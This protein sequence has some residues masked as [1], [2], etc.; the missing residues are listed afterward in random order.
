MISG[1]VDSSTW[2]MPTKLKLGYNKIIFIMWFFNLIQNAAFSVWA[3]FLP[4][5][6]ARK[7]IEQHLVGIMFC[8]Y[9]FSFA[10]VSPI[11]GLKMQRIGRRNI[12]VI[13]SVWSTLATIGFASLY[14]IHDRTAF[15]CWF[16]LFKMIL[17]IGSG[18]IQTVSYSILTLENP[19][20]VEFVCGCLEAA[21]GMGLWF[22][23]LIAIPFF[24]IGGYIAPFIAFWF[25]F[26][27]YSLTVKHMIPARV[28]VIEHATNI[29]RSNY[30]YKTML[31]NKRIV[32]ALFALSVNI[33]QFTFIDAFLV[34]RMKEDFG[35]EEIST[36]ILFFALGLGLTLSCQWVF[37]TLKFISFRRCFF[38]FFALNGLWT[39]MYGPTEL[40]PFGKSLVLVFLFMFLG[41]ITS[42]YTLVPILPEML[43][44]GKGD[45]KEEVLNDLAAG[46]FNM[47]WAFGEITGPF[48]GNVLY[49]VYGMPR[50]CDLVGAGVILFTILYFFFWDVSMPWNKSK[51]ELHT[52][53]VKLIKSGRSSSDM[54]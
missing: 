51:P 33:F 2:E 49:V 31:K 13:G 26:L 12:L 3:P 23:P 44:A 43:D 1:S 7:G 16:T 29:D 17:G 28:D 6:A 54:S 52:D 25:V 22:G 9:S 45:I 11:I 36:S 5:E 37:I 19:H 18:W 21:S 34:R 48:I 42:A 14:Y 32:F 40:L 24:H 47:A 10:I 27:T 39:F 41:G 46:L 15:I 53:N 4:S 8:A 35:L 38:I 50:A 20:Q 30:S